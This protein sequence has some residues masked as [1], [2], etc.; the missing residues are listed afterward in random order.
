MLCAPVNREWN[1]LIT[2]CTCKWTNNQLCAVWMQDVKDLSCSLSWIHPFDWIHSP[3]F[4]E[5]AGCTP[6]FLCAWQF[7]ASSQSL[8]LSFTFTL[9]SLCTALPYSFANDCFFL[10]FIFYYNC[11]PSNLELVYFS[12]WIWFFVRA[13]SFACK[14]SLLFVWVVCMTH[15]L[16]SIYFTTRRTCAKQ[17]KYT[18]LWKRALG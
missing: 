2:T 18:R 12:F 9:L 5:C 13:R 1:R 3:Q 15:V 7:H 10:F 17:M 16:H 11:V 14:C 8:S 4:V 6:E